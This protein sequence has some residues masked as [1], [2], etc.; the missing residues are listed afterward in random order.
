M[1]Y[2][3]DTFMVYYMVFEDRKPHSLQLHRNQQQQKHVHSPKWIKKVKD[4][5]KNMRM[6]E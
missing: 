6:S 4:V 3:Y 1:Y 2:I 5:W